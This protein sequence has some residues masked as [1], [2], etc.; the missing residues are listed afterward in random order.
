MLIF[1][2]ADLLDANKKARAAARF[3]GDEEEEEE[4]ED[5][6]IGSDDE[7]ESGEDSEDEEEEE[8]EGE[9]KKREDIPFKID[10]PEDYKSFVALLEG[11]NTKERAIIVDRIMV[12]NHYT[13]NRAQ[14]VPKMR[15]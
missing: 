3:G 4:V 15:V 5:I 9:G 8:E 1:I 14:N 13:L 11:R 6:D 12:G 10:A 7:D 2:L